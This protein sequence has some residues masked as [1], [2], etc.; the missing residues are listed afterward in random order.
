MLSFKSKTKF[1]KIPCFRKSTDWATMT[2]YLGVPKK[3]T[4]AEAETVTKA[5][6]ESPKLVQVTEVSKEVTLANWMRTTTPTQVERPIKRRWLFAS[7][8]ILAVFISRVVIHQISPAEPARIR[9]GTPIK[10]NV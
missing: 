9:L 4:T 1:K 3:K 7:M 5:E 10:S 8:L 6:V 2:A